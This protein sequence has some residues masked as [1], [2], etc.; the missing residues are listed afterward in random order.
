MSKE[1]LLIEISMILNDTN[2]YKEI[3]ELL[4]QT[5]MNID[6]E[7]LANTMEHS[8]LEFLNQTRC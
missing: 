1:E 3:E 8:I 6:I 5:E 7:E 2:A 4:N